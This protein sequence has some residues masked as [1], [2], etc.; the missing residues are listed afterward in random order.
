MEEEPIIK[1]K[2][3]KSRP[4]GSAKDLMSKLQDEANSDL[5]SE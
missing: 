4:G 3:T 5:F 2:G 1:K